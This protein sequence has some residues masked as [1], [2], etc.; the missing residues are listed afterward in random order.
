M[1]EIEIQT[2]TNG[3]QRDARKPSINVDHRRRIAAF[4]NNIAPFS[5]GL[6]VPHEMKQ[7]VQPEIKSRN[8]AQSRIRLAFCAVRINRGTNS[9]SA[10]C[11]KPGSKILRCRACSSPIGES[12]QMAELRSMCISGTFDCNEAW[13]CD[14]TEEK[15]HVFLVEGVPAGA[16]NILNGLVRNE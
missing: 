13:P 5:S 12:F 3:I 10:P 2:V 7:S 9:L 11:E 1:G 14:H 6:D 16:E 15:Y 4:D 8:N